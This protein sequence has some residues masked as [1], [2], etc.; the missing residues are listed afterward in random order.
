MLTGRQGIDHQHAEQRRTVD[1]HMIEVVPQLCQA[2]GDHQ[3]QAALAGRLTFQGSQ[4]RA[5]RQHRQLR[6]AG[7]QQQPL[8]QALRNLTTVLEQV[9]RA[10]FEAVRILTE[11]ARQGAVGIK[12]HQQDALAFIA[13]QPGEG[14]GGGG[15]AH[16]TLLIGDSPDSHVQT[17]S[18]RHDQ[19][20]QGAGLV[21]GDE[22]LTGATPGAGSP[23]DAA[24]CVPVDEFCK[25]LCGR[26]RSR[27]REISR[28]TRRLRARLTSL[29]LSTT[30]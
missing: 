10:V 18:R 25:V 24:D 20:G 9:E 19:P 8:R 17:S 15:L 3:A 26:N 4:R 23:G 28:T 6:M 22:D 29:V 27:L 14:N 5:G 21:A 13:E 2:L 11:I 7:G 30:G 1:Q 16:P 12:V